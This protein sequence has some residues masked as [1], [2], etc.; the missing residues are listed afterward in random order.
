MGEFVDA[1][2]TPVCL[3]LCNHNASALCDRVAHPASLCFKLPSTLSFEHGALAEPLSVG[4]HACERAGLVAG[5]TLLVTGAGPIAL[6]TLL[7]ARALGAGRVVLT[8]VRAERVSAATERFGADACVLIDPSAD[9]EV[10]RRA[11]ADALAT[12]DGLC[13][14][15]VECTGFSS[16]IRNALSLVRSGG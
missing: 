7:V 2:V 1:A 5:G 4:V 11:I 13:D 3:I 15:A 9:E 6:A 8:D 12:P 14:A 16:S 10:N